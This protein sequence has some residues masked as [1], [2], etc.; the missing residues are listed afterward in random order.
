MILSVLR[1]CY[2]KDMSTDETKSA[3]IARELREGPRPRGRPRNPNGPT[4]TRSLRIGPN[5][6]A[7]MEIATS[8]GETLNHIIDVFLGRYVARHRQNREP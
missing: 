3:R 8:R 6:D 4:P 5:W 1:W 2:R 7:A